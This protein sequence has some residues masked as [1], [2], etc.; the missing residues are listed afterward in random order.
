MKWVVI[1]AAGVLAVVSCDRDRARQDV[2]SQAE[3]VQA[4][5]SLYIAEEHVSRF[6]LRPDSARKFF[7][8]MEDRLFENMG[9]TREE[10]TRSFD[11]YVHHP[12]EWEAVYSALVDSLK[13][14]EQRQSVPAP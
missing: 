10:F 6:G 13:L 3:M 7:T 4:L 2:M 5:K 14:Q 8:R 11:Y 9:I 12:D 1:F